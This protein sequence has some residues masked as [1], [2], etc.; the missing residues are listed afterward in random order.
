MPGC[1]RTHKQT[2]LY[3]CIMASMEVYRGAER[4][5]CPEHNVYRVSQP[6]VK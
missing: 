5:E 3:T 6:Q 1:T 4:Q 2:G